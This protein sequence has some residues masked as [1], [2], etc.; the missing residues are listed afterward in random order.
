MRFL[1]LIRINENSGLVPS[2]KLMNDM[3]KL[4][5]ELTRAGKMV[6]TAGLRPTSEGTRIRMRQ[7]KLTTIDGPFV[8]TKEV[9]G[10]YAVLEADSMEEAIELTKR[11]MLLHEPVWEFECEVRQMEGPGVE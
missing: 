4:I 2:E 8:E 1:S 5:D 9:I 6:T 11:F 7:G 3:G 10:G